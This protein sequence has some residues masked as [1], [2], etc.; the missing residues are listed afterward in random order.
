ME[1]LTERNRAVVTA[2]AEQFYTHKDLHGAFEQYVAPHYLQHNPGIPDGREAAISRLSAMFSR[3]ETSFTVKRILVDGPYACIHL[4][5][6]PNPGSGQR[7]I[8]V[9][10]NLVR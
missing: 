8:V 1:T 6:R 4:H 10:G 7:R 2:F 5:A 3:P 9:T